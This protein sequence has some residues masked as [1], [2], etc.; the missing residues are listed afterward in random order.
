VV[1]L[2]RVPL[3]GS[4]PQR[5]ATQRSATP[6]R[7]SPASASQVAG[8]VTA[9][10]RSAGWRLS[11]VSEG[12]S[13]LVRRESGCSDCEA[14]EREARDLE[15]RRFLPALRPDTGPGHAPSGRH[16]GLRQAPVGVASAD[17]SHDRLWRVFWSA[18]VVVLLASG[19][20]W[21][22]TGVGGPESRGA[23]VRILGWSALV[24]PLV[25]LAAALR[26]RSPAGRRPDLVLVL[27]GVT[28]E[29]AALVRMHAVLGMLLGLG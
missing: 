29:A 13:L 2:A 16:G 28:L 25:V 17:P 9:D 14:R 10:L 12:R 24:L 20:A 1:P 23:A 22:A 6:Q 7:V 15:G 11:I 3:A 27:L 19:L 4:V 18:L 8:P 26:V 21:A 5:S